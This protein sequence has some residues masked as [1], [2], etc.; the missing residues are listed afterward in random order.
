MFRERRFRT[1]ETPEGEHLFYIKGMRALAKARDGE[2]RDE[3]SDDGRRT[4]KTRRRGPC[5]QEKAPERD[6]RHRCSQI[7]AAKEGGPKQCGE[8]VR[9]EVCDKSR[10]CAQREDRQP[11]RP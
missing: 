5:G 3:A 1:R 7:Q 10:S 9:P 8:A 6:R 11:R 2:S 4:D